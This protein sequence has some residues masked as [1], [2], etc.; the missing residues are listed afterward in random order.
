MQSSDS[1]NRP[2]DASDFISRRGL[3]PFRLGAGETL[4][5]KGDAAGGMY[6]VLSGRIDILIFGRLLDQVERGGVIG[7]M[8]LVDC[9]HRS[10]AALAQTDADLVAIDRA[11]F[12]ELISEEPRFALAVITIMVERLARVARLIGET[13]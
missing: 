9:T 11:L 5:F 3:A 10:A 6:V 2:F 13:K 7:E 1:I 12:L 8:A 4:F